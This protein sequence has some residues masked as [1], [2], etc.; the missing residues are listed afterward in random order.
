MLLSC[1]GPLLRWTTRGTTETRTT[2]SQRLEDRYHERLE[3]LL[4]LWVDC[5]DQCMRSGESAELG[6]CLVIVRT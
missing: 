4:G 5:N 3:R 2:R 6:E 1:L